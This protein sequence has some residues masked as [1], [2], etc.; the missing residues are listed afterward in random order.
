[1]TFKVLE[2]TLNLIYDFKDTI[3][4]KTAKSSRQVERFLIELKGNLKRLILV[5][6]KF[7]DKIIEDQ[8]ILT[9]TIPSIREQN[10]KL[11]KKRKKYAESIFLKD[12]KQDINLQMKLANETT[13]ELFETKIK[14]ENILGNLDK[15]SIVLKDLK[16]NTQQQIIDLY[17]G[18]VIKKEEIDRLFKSMNNKSDEIIALESSILAISATSLATTAIPVYGWAI[19]L[20]LSPVH[21]ALQAASSSLK[22]AQQREIEEYTD[23]QQR[24]IEQRVQLGRIDMDIETANMLK[25]YVKEQK[26]VILDLSSM[27][28]DANDWSSIVSQLDSLSNFGFTIGEEINADQ[29]EYLP[30]DLN[31]MMKGI[32]AIENSARQL[33]ITF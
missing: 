24:L 17:K 4:F 15:C 22:D 8:K 3:F 11:L 25:N 19:S 5:N 26:R 7:T 9:E 1:L 16:L 18:A 33:T 23:L 20:S 27:T 21:I 29:F 31:V 30:V 10:D 2:K 13:S 28:E 14:A 12:I 6:K 32:S